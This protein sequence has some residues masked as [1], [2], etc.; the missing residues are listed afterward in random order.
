M[1]PYFS[2]NIRAALA[3]SRVVNV[4][5]SVFLAV[6]M[7]SSQLAWQSILSNVTIL[8]TNNKLIASHGHAGDA[9]KV[10]PCS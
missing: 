6:R 1:C 10:A 5:I 4:V 8:T 3:L 7:F 2:S 9:I